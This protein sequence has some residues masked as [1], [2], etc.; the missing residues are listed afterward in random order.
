M[1]GRRV[2]HHLLDGCELTR[3]ARGGQCLGIPPVSR[4]AR[5]VVS[6]TRRCGYGWD[7]VDVREAR[8]HMA[9]GPDR[10]SRPGSG[11][12][13]R[14]R[15]AVQ[16]GACASRPGRRR[17]RPGWRAEAAASRH[18]TSWM[19]SCSDPHAISRVG[20]PTATRGS[21]PSQVLPG[22]AAELAGSIRGRPTG[23]HTTMTVRSLSRPCVIASAGSAPPLCSQT[24][25]ARWLDLRGEAWPL[26][27]WASAPPHIVLTPAEN[28]FGLRVTPAR[29]DEAC[30]TGNL[31]TLSELARFQAPPPARLPAAL[32][33]HRVRRVGLARWGCDEGGLRE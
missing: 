22:A 28:T 10:P 24:Q 27:S 6:R 15:A 5:T 19:N 16:R 12:S 23:S 3:A 31:L 4:T 8:H 9:D 1:V 2:R 17:E 21:A 30:W 7:A 29:D 25:E 14:G 11:R 32:R 26:E 33:R 20:L 18:H 13:A